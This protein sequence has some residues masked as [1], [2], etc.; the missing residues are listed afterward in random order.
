VPGLGLVLAVR[1]GVAVAV[2]VPEGVGLSRYF[3]R[4]RLCVVCSMRASSCRIPRSSQYVWI[5]GDSGPTYVLS[6]TAFWTL[7]LGFILIAD[8]A[9][10]RHLN[11]IMFLDGPML[12]MYAKIFLGM[13]CM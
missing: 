6:H 2:A 8:A 11:V 3:L 7:V 13:P 10:W 1:G 4:V 12:T 5:I 9:F